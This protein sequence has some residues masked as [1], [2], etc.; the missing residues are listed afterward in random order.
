MDPK[1]VRELSRLIKP[2]R[3]RNACP[4]VLAIF[5]GWRN[6]MI[7]SS[8]YFMLCIFDPSE[9]NLVGPVCGAGLCC[10]LLLA[11]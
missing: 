4:I 2:A 5:G 10:V 11:D 1:E 6:V 3:M 7:A 8:L 9:P